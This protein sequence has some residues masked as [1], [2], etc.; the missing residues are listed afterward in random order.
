MKGAKLPEVLMIKLNWI[1]WGAV[2]DESRTYGASGG[3][4]RDNFKPLP[5]C[6]EKESGKSYTLL[7][8]ISLK[9]ESKKEALDASIRGK[10]EN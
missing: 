2:C 4:G 5:I 10:C 3:K 8:L 9:E 1:S 6:H 7:C